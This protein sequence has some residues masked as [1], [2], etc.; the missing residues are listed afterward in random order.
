MLSIEENDSLTRDVSVDELIGMRVMIVQNHQIGTIRY[1][2]DGVVSL[3]CH[4]SEKKYLYPAAFAGTL[5]LED[6]DLNERI[7]MQGQE[8]SF[9][10]FKKTYRFA[11]TNEIDFL[12]LTGGKKYRIVDGE[13][14]ASRDGE[15]LYA[16]DTD[17]DLHFP[18]GTTVK[19]WFP[20]KIVTGYVVSCEDFT[21]L[22]RTM[23]YIGETIDSVEFTSEQW[24]LLEALMDR[25]KCMEPSRDSIA[26]EIACNG[27]KKLIPWSNI[28]CGQNSAMNRATSEKVTFI[29]GPPGTGKT[30]TLANI[31]LEHIEKGR[32]V[33]MLSY[34]NVS[35]DGALMR[36]ANKADLEA[37]RVIR[38]GYPRIK[39]LID[40]CNLTSYQYVLQNNPELS[41]EYRELN[42]KKRSLKR[43]DPE[44]IEINKCINRLR[45][46][47]LQQER[48][49]IYRADFIATTVSKAT[50]DP[51]IYMQQFDVVIFDEASM[52]YVP[53]IIFASSLA[54]SFF[55]C[56]GDF[57]QLPAIVQNNTDDRLTKD[58]F[59]YTGITSAVEDNQSHEWL[60]M[61][62]L[63]FRMH[64]DIADF[65]SQNMYQGRLKT[66]DKISE[67]RQEIAMCDPVPGAAMSM[68]DL[69]GMYSVCTKTMDGSRINIMSALMCVRI[70]EKNLKNYEVGIITPYSAQSRLIIAMLRD[71]QEKNKKWLR[72]SCATV[73]QFQGSEKPV[74]VYDSVDCFR[75]P[76]PGM[77]LSS[78][79]NNSAN[80]LFNVALTRAKGK[81]VLVTNADYLLR[82]HLSKKLVFTKAITKIQ[83]EQCLIRGA[84]VLDE[85]MPIEDEDPCI[86]IGDRENSW[87]RYIEDIKNSKDSIHMEIP[88]V[89]DENDIAIE[90][91]ASALSMKRESGV[92][93]SIRTPESIDLPL[94]FQEYIKPNDY[95]TNP[96]TVIDK[97]TVWFGQPLY[98]ADFISE[99]DIL[100]TEYFPC[101]RFEGKHMARLIQAFLEF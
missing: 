47:L 44:R 4:G 64:W 95:V 10:E 35:V 66:T 82:K 99:G 89:M 11:L 43:K 7:L 32:R 79:K 62:D 5:E 55:V 68:V 78:M 26:Y 73:H 86:Y 84:S 12:K 31:A 30:E 42:E 77:M 96:V 14:I 21:I 2:K 81:F 40:N 100:D 16:F 33:L 91:L 63:Q 56:L 98:A 80:R 75:M 27:R 76:Y 25:I 15:Y 36:V 65:V 58:I 39:E 41:K 52:A 74:I 22:I 60:V 8:A 101:I 48:D 71:L 46:L 38:Y 28:R 13:R 3:D 45:D 49:L 93:I 6:E 94:A 53:Q 17:S 83:R 90:E 61:L 70:A 67:S 51:S 57:C 37:G 29:W 1:I 23:E 87:K 69:S 20:E 18:D 50:V 54:K 88:D 59:E 9:E 72:V 19:L 24:Q 92:H 85:M 97:K 34:S